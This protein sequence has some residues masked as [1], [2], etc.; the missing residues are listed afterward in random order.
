MAT[1]KLQ[2]YRNMGHIYE[3]LLWFQYEMFS[4]GSCIEGL[5]LSWCTIL[6][7]SGNFRRWGLA[8]E[9]RLLRVRPLGE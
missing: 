3:K 5:I 4:T 6:G 8:R 2:N 7:G 1:F 9:S